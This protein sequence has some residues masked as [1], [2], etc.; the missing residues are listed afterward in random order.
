MKRKIKLCDTVVE[1]FYKKKHSQKRDI[2]TLLF[3]FTVLFGCALKGFMV[4]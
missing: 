1:I 3:N 2:K 4:L